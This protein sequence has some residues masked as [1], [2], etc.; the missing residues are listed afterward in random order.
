M[1]GL[2]PQPKIRLLDTKKMFKM[3]NLNQSMNFL[4]ARVRSNLV[5]ARGHGLGTN[6]FAATKRGYQ[7]WSRSR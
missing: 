3:P 1:K 6:L 7:R 4:Q 2:S 5:A